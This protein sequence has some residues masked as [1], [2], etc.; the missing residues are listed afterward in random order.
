MLII[1]Q[2]MFGG[3]FLCARNCSRCQTLHLKAEVN[4][5]LRE[6]TFVK[7]KKQIYKQI[8]RYEKYQVAM[9]TIKKIKI[10]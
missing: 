8:N 1:L 10:V 2:Q 5:G 3:C 4:F 7:A 6:I 9:G